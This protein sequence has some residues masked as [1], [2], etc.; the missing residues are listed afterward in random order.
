[1]GVG[2]ALLLLAID[3]RRGTIW[4]PQRMAFALRAGELLDL[5]LAGRATVDDGRIEVTDAS[6]TGNDRLD[7]TLAEIS[8]MTAPTVPS[9]VRGTTPGIGMRYLSRLE[10]QH[11]VQ[12]GA[13]RG[14]SQPPRI[15]LIDPAR[16]DGIQ[17]RVDRVAR[18]EPA[19]EEDRSL[20]GLVYACSLDARLYGGLRR[21]ALRRRLARLGEQQTAAVVHLAS[22]GFEPVANASTD[23]VTR[24]NWALV[25]MLRHEYESGLY[26]QQYDS[27]GGHHGGESHHHGSESH[28]HGVESHHHGG[29]DT[30]GGHHG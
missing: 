26:D 7:E 22:A 18:G 28:H 10:D 8:A 27:G 4:A 1:M 14:S 25:G 5:V 3:P 19:S 13:G 16:R 2:E 24:L 6:G 20:A 30:G 9:W 29:I 12:I 17:A 11:V 21:R 23:V 15:T